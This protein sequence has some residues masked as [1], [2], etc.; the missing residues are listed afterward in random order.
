MLIEFIGGRLDG[1]AIEKASINETTCEALKVEY[2]TRDFPFEIG[3]CKKI[4]VLYY[5]KPNT[6]KFYFDKIEEV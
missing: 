4:S 1:E 6:N 5:R 3:D 2:I